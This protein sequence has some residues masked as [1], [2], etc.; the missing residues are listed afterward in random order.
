ME[1]LPPEP[2]NLRFLRR[3][4]TALTATMIVGIAAIVVLFLIRFTG[5][6]PAQTAPVLPDRIT[7]PDGERA[8]AVTVGT[9][10]F[11][12][13]T[14]SQKILIFDAESGSL[15]QRIQIDAE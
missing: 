13:V 8:T 12:V 14:E 9:G 4:V 11:A 10:W 7:L 2:E 5:E 6:T 15:R 3:L 1:D